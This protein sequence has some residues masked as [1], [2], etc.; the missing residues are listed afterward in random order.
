MGREEMRDLTRETAEPQDK[1]IMEKPQVIS[2]IVFIVSE[3]SLQAGHGGI[4]L[5]LSTLGVKAD[6]E[7]EASLGHIAS[8]RSV[9]DT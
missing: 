5:H 7:F 4:C 1:M 2:T 6:H 3:K 8:S 9:W